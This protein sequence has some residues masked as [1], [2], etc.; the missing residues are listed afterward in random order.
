MK[1]EPHSV[2]IEVGKRIRMQ[3]TLHRISQTELG[4][5]IGVTFQQVQKYERGSNRVS[6]SKL[7]EIANALD[8][9]VRLFFDNIEETSPPPSSTGGVA[10]SRQA[11]LLSVAFLAIADERIRDNILRLVQAISGGSAEL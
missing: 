4:N 5:R 6:A 11:A 2:D 10:G 3:R 7:V 9:D 1:S 8:V